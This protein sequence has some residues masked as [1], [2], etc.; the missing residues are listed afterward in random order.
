MAGKKKV[1]WVILPVL[2]IGLYG[3]LMLTT[4]PVNAIAASQGEKQDNSWT[5][6]G[7]DLVTV[8]PFEEAG[9]SSDDLSGRTFTRTNAECALD[10]TGIISHWPLNEAD[11]AT[12]FVDK[13]G[14][15][16]GHCEG[17]ACPSKTKGVISGAFAFT[18]SEDDSIFVP[19]STDFDWLRGD[20]FSIGV[21]VKTTQ[22]CSGNKVFLG[23]YRWT[24]GVWWVGCVPS[25]DDPAIGLAGFRLRDDTE[26]GNVPRQVTGTT[27]INDGRW[28]Y[29]V[30]VRDGN[31][32]ENHI[33]VD[34]KLE[35]TATGPEYFGDFENTQRLTIGSYDDPMDYY[36]DGSLDEI[37][38]YDR[39]L[40]A[41]EIATYYLAC[42]PPEIYLPMIL[43]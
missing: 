11:G 38:I 22:D 19:A 27:W 30:G 23:R 18:A 20:S 10:P 24:E 5:S 4:N 13:V 41:N 8:E 35:K 29:V 15:H 9:I 39:A 14:G 33:Y 32:D 40:S 16:H 25:L 1:Q 43:N 37:V 2:L 7:L 17:S 34:G 3:G 42:D 31:K 36:L 6:Y 28:H 26:E 21:W 12:K